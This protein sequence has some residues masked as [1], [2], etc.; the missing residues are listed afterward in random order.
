M[1]VHAGV[2][3]VVALLN[4]CGGASESEGGE[5]GVSISPDPSCAS[6]QRWTGGNAESAL[7]HPGRACIAC[8]LQGEGPAFGVAGT[9]FAGSE[10]ANDCLGS[11]DAEVVLH[12]ATGKSVSLTANSAGNFSY[13]GS[14]T[15]PLEAEVRH[16][17]KSRSMGTPV[18]DGDCNRC[19]TAAGEN[20]APGRILLP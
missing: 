8:H 9:V 11:A 3:C 5:E 6:G 16:A 12:D 14:L 13:S 17:G 4:A 15:F 19:H 20:G 10:E 1:R 7:M 2:W 18:P